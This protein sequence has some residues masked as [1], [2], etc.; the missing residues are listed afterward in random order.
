MPPMN[1][2]TAESVATS[3]VAT[4]KD[5]KKAM[6]V[7]GNVAQ[8]P[9]SKEKSET[10]V[11]P[12]VV[13]NFR[14]AGKPDG[15]LTED[16]AKKFLGWK[17]V[18][19][20]EIHF[21][22]VEGN[23][24][25]CVNNQ[26]N[27]PF[28]EKLAKEYAQTILHKQWCGPSGNGGSINSEAI[29]ITKTESIGSGQH[30]LI[31]LVLACQMWRA[32]PEKYYL[33][34]DA[35]VMD[36]LM[37]LGIDDTDAVL[38]TLDTGRRRSD[39]DIIYRSEHFADLASG[40]RQV[41]STAAAHAVALLW[42]RTGVEEGLGVH[43]TTAEKLAMLDRH[44]RLVQCVRH[45]V[46]ENKEKGISNLLPLGNCAALMFLMAASET[47]PTEYFKADVREESLLD[48]SMYDNA[49][50][51][52]VNLVGDPK[53]KSLIDQVFR[54]HNIE[55]GTQGLSD[56][57]RRALLC[58]AWLNRKSMT[59]ASL[60]LKY[61][62]DR[63]DGTKL[64]TENVTVGGI[65]LGACPQDKVIP[66]EEDDAK[67]EETQD[68]PTKSKK[69]V[70]LPKDGDTVWVREKGHDPWQGKLLSTRT[71]PGGKTI[72][73]VQFEMSGKTKTAELDYEI[74][75]LDKPTK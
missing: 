67:D 50:D 15:P 26:S 8:E 9:S 27:R 59:K 32:D 49:C 36:T 35:P 55:A 40:P 39:S 66:G 43:R 5:K 2:E 44:P 41:C 17:V 20:G 34:K 11:Y 68:A 1:R 65:D 45:V 31:A 13:G 64:F 12:E 53:I 10:I 18:T 25:L 60:Q 62:V 69:S 46:T 51:F 54:D 38:N 16:H 22:D 61:E 56:Q 30:R 74:L 14:F 7:L 28:S 3:T 42:Y 70:K 52:F 24:V 75:S 6:R 71:S 73:K 33:W 23:K 48:F 58:K 47:A 19:S 4:K 63:E 72:A 37:V 29:G 57:E 21:T